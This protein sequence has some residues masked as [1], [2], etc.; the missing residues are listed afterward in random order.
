MAAVWDLAS[1]QATILT[2]DEPSIWG[3]TFS[4]DGSRVA[5]VSPIYEMVP[6]EIGVFEWDVATGEELRMFP[7]DT[8]SVY[9]VAYSPDGGLLAAGVQEGNTLIWDTASGELVRTLTGH[10]ALVSRLAFSPDGKRLASG[11]SDNT[12]K[13]WDVTT[14]EEL[15]TMY[16]QSGVLNG[17]AASRDGTR[18]ATAAA[19]GTVRTYVV[20]TDELVALARSRVTRSLTTEECQKYLHVDECPPAP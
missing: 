18:I 19:D 12:V 7:V 10:T 8:F 15:T 9:S 11:A 5:T 20:D 3:I 17:M 4:P 16:V 6:E 13:L 1:G 2:Q 14:G